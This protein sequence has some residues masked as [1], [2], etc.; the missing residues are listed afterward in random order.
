MKASD[1]IIAI[2]TDADAPIFTVAHYGIVE[3]CLDVLPA[4]LETV[5]ATKG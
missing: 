4:L 5:A 2:N 3:D 1:L